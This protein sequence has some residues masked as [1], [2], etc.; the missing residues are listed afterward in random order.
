V[1]RT[2]FTTFAVAPKKAA[3]AQRPNLRFHVR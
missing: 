2:I 1:E 3:S